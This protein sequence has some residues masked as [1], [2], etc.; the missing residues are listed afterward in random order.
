MER[1]SQRRWLAR[2]A[3]R[4][5]SGPDVVDYDGIKL[6]VIGYCDQN[7]IAYQLLQGDQVVDPKTFKTE[8]GDYDQVKLITAFNDDNKPLTVKQIRS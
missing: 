2:T 8:K 4:H 6:R 1:P 5:A 7:G 3:R